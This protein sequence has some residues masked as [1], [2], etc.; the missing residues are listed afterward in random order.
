[1]RAELEKLSENEVYIVVQEIKN[2]EL[3]AQIRIAQN[4]LDQD[5]RMEAFAEIQRIVIEDAVQL[6]NYERGN[7]YVQ[8]PEVKGI[9][10]RQISPDPDFTNAYIVENP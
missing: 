2:P 8:V 10:Y 1:M 4:S 9:V 6:P 5:V 3:D 7:V